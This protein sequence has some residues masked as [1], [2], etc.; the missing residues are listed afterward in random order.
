M[1]Q[2]P[3]VP[4]VAREIGLDDTAL[5]R[6]HAGIAQRDAIRSLI[7]DGMPGAAVR[8]LVRLLP[9]SYVVPWLCQCATTA[10]LA[11]DEREGVRLAEAWSRDRSETHRRAAL[12]HAAARHYVG[13]GALVAATAGWSEGFLLDADGKEV[14]PVAT[15]LM[16][17]VAGAALLTLAAAGDDFEAGCRALVDAGV[18]LL[19][20]E[21]S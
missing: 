6:L 5:R 17:V 16:A 12:A 21:E 10:P 19:R 1:T 15:H 7:D 18:P 9:R 11:E 20:S 13:V 8:L 4:D 3:S 2:T 14:A